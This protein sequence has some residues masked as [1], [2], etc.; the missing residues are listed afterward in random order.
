MAAT[1]TPGITV[2]AAG[3]VFIDKRH[4]GTRICL[5]LGPP[6][7]RWSRPFSP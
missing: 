5:R 6:E 7:P 4:R 3:N 1:R 2:D